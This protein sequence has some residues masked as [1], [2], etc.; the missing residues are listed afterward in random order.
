MKSY[1]L[2]LESFLCLLL[3]SSTK[4]QNDSTSVT[5]TYP[6]YAAIAMGNYWVYQ[7]FKIGLNGAATP[8]HITDSTYIEKDT[9]IANE[10]YFKLVNI[11][12]NHPTQPEITF[13]RVVENRIEDYGSMIL[14]TLNSS[15]QP[16]FSLSQ[17]TC[18]IN[19]TSYPAMTT[20]VAYE[21]YIIV[22]PKM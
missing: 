15:P 5:V 20:L 2:I 19:C 22:M 13:Q 12:S 1:S 8:L 18:N 9:V 16:T 10:T 7:E 11:P 6:N 17:T 4:K 21:Y 14:F 3:F